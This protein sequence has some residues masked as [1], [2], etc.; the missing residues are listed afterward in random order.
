MSFSPWQP[1]DARARRDLR[2]P[3]L[4]L[5]LLIVVAG[6]LAL[7]SLRFVP[8]AAQVP[9]TTPSPVAAPGTPQ[10]GQGVL[11]PQPP[12]PT[13]AAEPSEAPTA[14]PP[15][16][17]TPTAAP[18]ATSTP[19]PPALRSL[20]TLEAS[21]VPARDPY[22]LAARLRYKN[23]KPL[24][25]TTGRPPGNYQ[26]GHKDAFNISDIENKNYYTV[27]A[28]VREVTEH[29]Y[30]YAQDG[31][32]IDQGVLMALARTFEEKIYPTNR[33][34]FG[35]E[36]TPGVDNDPRITVLFAPLRGAGGSYSAADEYTRAVNP[37]SNEREMF[38]ISTTSGWGGLEGTLAHELQ[39]MIHWHEHA[40]QDIWLNEGASVL[41]SALNGYDVLGVDVD[42][43]QDPDVQL[44]AWQPSP[45]LARANYGAAFL[46]LDYLMA[47]YGGEQIMRAVLAAPEP[48]AKAVDTALRSLGHSESF[49]DV[50]KQW[51]LANLVD[52]LPGAGPALDYPDRE[53]QVSPQVVLDH[54]PTGYSGQVSQFGARY[55]QLSAPEDGTG[56]LHVDFTGQTE[57]PAVT[58]PA[59]SGSAIWWSNRG[60]LAN[61]TMTRD[62]DLTGLGAATLSCYIWFDIEQ[63]FDYAYIEASTD[64]GLTWDTL[65]GKYTSS[66][67]P[68]GTNYGS[69]YTGKSADKPGA[70]QSG[71]L[72][73]K[74][75]LGA[76][77][78]KK[79]ML[80]F[81]YIT[82]DGYN[83]QGIAID[84]VSIPELGYIDNAESDSGW[85][86]EGF[87][88]LDNKLPQSYYLAVARI[89]SP[90]VDIQQVE[91]DASGNASF[92]VEGL[93]A[94]GP[95]S[96][97]V[98][99][100]AGLTPY[101]LQRPTYELSVRP[102]K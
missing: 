87:V 50:F 58:A 51:T 6:G 85:Q 3:L 28:T 88:R 78:G 91:V 42:F 81:E 61:T 30:W 34:L 7:L 74:I 24:A 35:S 33:A 83:A 8:L 1:S 92:N 19:L 47:H 97:A 37:F 26:V 76:Y 57:I 65:K 16:V 2:R 27:N 17:D 75:D 41:A 66:T 49:I 73:E 82:D 14:T 12:T 5:A 63:D 13:A 90:G 98:L 64:N 95:Y 59:H 18:P 71:W 48:G 72:H 68:N 96:K 69:A 100:I 53:V 56:A 84:D 60:D 9:A 70:D 22:A 102:V 101:N 62:F 93:G 99:V 21:R 4:A 80:R 45:G 10:R 52:G 77:V 44:S 94:A 38:Y 29:A 46:F 15:P 43:M 39:H 79:I 20:Q 25:R 31:A 55:V 23:G 11:G 54:Y 86:S 32:P 40:N 36:W 89:G 67:N